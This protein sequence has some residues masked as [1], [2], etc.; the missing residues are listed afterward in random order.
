M[1]FSRLLHFQKL[2]ALKE[3]L[4][5]LIFYKIGYLPVPGVQHCLSTAGSFYCSGSPETGILVSQET[6]AAFPLRS[7]GTFVNGPA[8][9]W[10]MSYIGRVGGREIDIILT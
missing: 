5:L 2:K 3:E 6:T 4:K 9:F 8:A 7:C 10:E 1:T